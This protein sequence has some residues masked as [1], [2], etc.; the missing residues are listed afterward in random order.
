MDILI[1]VGIVLLLM[2]VAWLPGFFK[3]L[4]LKKEIKVLNETASKQSEINVG[5]NVQLRNENDQLKKENE[6]FRIS[7]LSLRNKP[8]KTEVQ[9]LYLYDAAIC[10]M[11]M[12]APGFSPAW[13]NALQ[14]AEEERAGIWTGRIPWI[15]KSIRPSLT[16]RKQ[17]QIDVQIDRETPQE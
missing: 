9:T 6:N 5:G 15:R 8:S 10:F 16:R 2:L 11:Q 7:L 13:G 3:Q 17:Q 14:Q 1:V 4:G 12:N